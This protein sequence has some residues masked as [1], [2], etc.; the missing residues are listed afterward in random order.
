MG[1]QTANGNWGLG[2]SC[3]YLGGNISSKKP[4]GEPG[5]DLKKLSSLEVFRIHL[6]KTTAGPVIILP[7]ERYWIKCSF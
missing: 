3:G 6:D 4:P 7:W 2:D 5:I 1:K